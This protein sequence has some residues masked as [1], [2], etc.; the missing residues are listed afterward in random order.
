MKKI[1]SLILLIVIFTSIMPNCAF[2]SEQE[3]LAQY[4][5]STTA[6][7]LLGIEHTHTIDVSNLSSE[8]LTVIEQLIKL[9]ES[10]DK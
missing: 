3:V 5:G 4:T 6:S 9:F 2:A 1:I 7:Y 10:D 8:Q